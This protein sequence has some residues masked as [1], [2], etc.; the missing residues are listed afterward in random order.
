VLGGALIVVQALVVRAFCWLCMV[1]DVSAIVAGAAGLALV[2]GRLRDEHAESP[3]GPLRSWAWAALGALA[4]AAPMTWPFL[5]P[6]GALPAG[7]RER[8]VAGKINVVEFVDFECP[9]CRLFHPTLKKVVDEYGARVNFVRLDLPLESHPQARGAAK[10]HLCADSQRAGDRMADVLFELEA[11]DESALAGAAKSLGLDV[12]RFEECLAS[13]KTEERLRGVESILRDSGMLQGLPTTFVG[14]AMLVG[15][16]D[17]VALR[18][19]FERAARGA[20][21]DGVP[22]V[23]YLAA[24][25][26]AAGGVVFAGRRRTSQAAARPASD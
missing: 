3:S 6:A 25:V 21:D 14:S 13:P 10:A 11:L 19:A 23:A 9:F 18:D 4:V 2:I 7:V 16:H 17:D 15:A 5:R 8:H 1:A 24:L 26:A 22:G 20:D 12:K